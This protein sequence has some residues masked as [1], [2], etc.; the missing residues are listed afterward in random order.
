M[1]L[2]RP[3]DLAHAE[4]VSP[5]TVR[6]YERVGFMPPAERT[7]TGQRRYGLCHAQA[8]QAARAMIVGYGWQPALE[9]MRAAH[10]GDLAAVLARVDARHA[11]LDRRRQEFDRVLEAL[12][13]YLPRRPGS[14]R[15]R[16]PGAGCP[17]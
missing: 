9:I 11:D 6:R 4:G 16:P 5:Q 12:P 7:P 2:F 17:H 13:P 10:Q 14:T 3:I 8:M 15:S 1:S